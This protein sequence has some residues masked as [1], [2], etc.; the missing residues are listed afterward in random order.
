[1]WVAQHY[2]SINLSLR[3]RSYLVRLLSEAGTSEA[4][5]IR[6]AINVAVRQARAQ[7]KRERE[8]AE[9]VR[10]EG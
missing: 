6:E 4:T 1:M 7:A 8:W 3:E 5:E 2:A 10:T 9:R